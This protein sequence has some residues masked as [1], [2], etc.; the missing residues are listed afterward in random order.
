MKSSRDTLQ[1][2]LCLLK[3][4]DML[5]EKGNV[6]DLIQL[7]KG[8]ISNNPELIKDPRDLFVAL[9]HN[10]LIHEKKV[11]FLIHK[12]E[13]LLLTEA[14]KI[15]K[16]YER[17]HLDDGGAANSTC[18][19]EE[20][21]CT[22]F[23]LS[24]K[25]K[26]CPN[27]VRSQH[28]Q[29]NCDFF[30]LADISEERYKRRHKLIEEI[31]LEKQHIEGL[32]K[33]RMKR[34][35]LIKTSLSETRAKIDRDFEE[36]KINVK[37]V[38]EGLIRKVQEKQEFHEGQLKGK[39]A[40]IQKF[41]AEV[42]RF[43]Q[44]EKGSF[45]DSL[46][47]YLQ[48]KEGLKVISNVQTEA[49]KKNEILNKM[50]VS[51]LYKKLQHDGTFG[52]FTER[53]LIG[54]VLVNFQTLLH[55]FDSRRTKNGILLVS[56]DCSVR[57][58][59]VWTHLVK[60]DNP[61]DPVVISNLTMLNGERHHSCFA[62]GKMVFITKHQYSPL[63]N[64]CVESVASLVI[65]TVREGCWITSI[66]THYSTDGPKDRFVISTSFD[67]AVRE[68]SV[69]GSALRVIETQGI[70]STQ[71]TRV[72]YC[73]NKFAI[74][75]QDCNDIIIVDS[76]GTVKQCGVFVRPSSVSGMLPID[77]LWTGSS[78]LV[79]YITHG[80]DKEWRVIHYAPDGTFDKEC[81]V[82]AY[83]SP[84]DVPISVTR[85]GYTG[86]VT[87]ANTSFRTFGTGYN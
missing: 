30:V 67:Q 4:A 16:D 12:L 57:K 29:P 26:A 84:N 81:D 11:D 9:Q 78:W 50:N 28:S 49:V 87:F 86:C 3:V 44:K 46:R 38:E 5:T 73:N 66:S 43:S 83:S 74:I 15:L 77:V 68:Y 85:W 17:S 35:S 58:K 31:S 72:A 41:S 82:G 20:R 65:D 56:V 60:I 51:F 32:E 18:V 61:T 10:N 48:L 75:S 80:E 76:N 63:G 22:Y 53:T 70:V 27:C 34:E 39:R 45:G 8:D 47:Q 24:C 40:E 64:A 54:S 6:Q 69:A 52:T 25:S 62:V 42:D 33:L 13:K 37:R 55:F 1:F 36:L 71:V 21:E 19:H 23:C 7:C 79:L 14:V 2:K 59:E